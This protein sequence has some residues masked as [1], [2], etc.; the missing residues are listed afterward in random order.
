MVGQRK[1]YL[2]E[3]FSGHSPNLDP[4][5]FSQDYPR[6]F[7]DSREIGAAWNDLSTRR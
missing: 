3:E 5:I 6:N 1:N 7:G 2:N 4:S